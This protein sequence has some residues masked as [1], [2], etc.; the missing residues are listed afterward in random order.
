V[1][2]G[3]VRR[4][5]NVYSFTTRRSRTQR[6]KMTAAHEHRITYCG[7][8]VGVLLVDES[9]ASPAVR[10]CHTSG[11]LFMSR[12]AYKHTAT[13]IENS[14]LGVAVFDSAVRTVYVQSSVSRKDVACPQMNW[15]LALGCVG[16]LLLQILRRSAH[17]HP[18]TPHRNVPAS[19]RRTCSFAS[20]LTGSSR[21]AG[22]G[23]RG[24][25]SESGT[26]RGSSR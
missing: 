2:P 3:L 15:C 8:G 12:F 16:Y 21:A 20:L 9:L 4:Y 25:A 13:L 26:R 5:A 22:C 11:K 6:R 19:R 24:T 18:N 7:D 23:S 1:K 14:L 10:E 17:K